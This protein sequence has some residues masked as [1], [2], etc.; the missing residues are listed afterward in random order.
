MADPL[1][2]NGPS[3]HKG[4][5]AATNR[6]GRYEAQVREA[7]DDGWILG[8]DLEPPAKPPTEI[9]IERPKSLL[10]RN[11][12]PD[13]GFDRSVNPYRG[14]EHGCVYCYARPSHAWVGLSPGLDFETKITVKKG[15]TEVLA[16]QLAKPGYTPAPVMVAGNTDAWQPVER[17][18]AETRAILD[19]LAETR[20]PT[21]CVTKS[22]LILRDIDLLAE[23]AA[24]NLVAVGI[25]ITS[26]DRH[27]SRKLEPRAA[28]P[29]R[30][31]E[32]IKALSEAGIPVAVLVSPVI[33]FLNDWELERILEA[34]AK[35]GAT[36]AHYVL[37]RLPL[38]LKELFT[39]WLEVHAPG[40]KDHVLNLLT[41]SRNGQL[42]IPDFKTR[43]K[44]TG[45]HAELLAKRFKLAIRR[46]GLILEGPD[47]KQLASHL[48]KPPVPKGGQYGL[49]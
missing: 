38:E 49:F 42:Y 17:E 21:L 23:M 16:R 5:G 4:R 32:V 37:L 36:S 20:H 27:L 18:R 26:L 1:D 39:E 41:E 47:D 34:A 48:F 2:P 3:A 43:M 44:G 6:T 9:A 7:V 10:S 45:Q 25:S 40:K 15:A 29:E 24:R 31:L 14:C 12:S 8:E 13:L 30:R 33:P 46:Y 28:A 11:N 35:A 22:A 19:L